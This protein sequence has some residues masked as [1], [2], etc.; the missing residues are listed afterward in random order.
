MW[1]SENILVSNT[2]PALMELTS[3]IKIKKHKEAIITI[4]YHIIIT[5][6]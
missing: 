2:V 1:S 3:K 4:L 6:M 5:M